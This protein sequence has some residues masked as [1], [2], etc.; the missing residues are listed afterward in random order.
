[1]KK[2][3]IVIVLAISTASVFLLFAGNNKRSRPADRARVERGRF[4]VAIGGCNDCHTP[5]KMGE[6]GPEPDLARYLSGHPADTKLPPP[7]ALAGSPWN[8]VTAGLTAWSGPWGVSYAA[9]LTP[10]DETGLGR[11][12]E[13]QFLQIVHTGR[14]LGK[15][16]GILPPMPIQN[17]QA[18]REE[19]L[20]AIFAYLRSQPAVR[21]HVPTATEPVASH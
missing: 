10:D 9:N 18:T 8:A 6:R 13:A 12:T 1:M 11:W 21:N 7:P 19:D 16:R 15:G 14:H 5:L 2:R 4:L 20:K 3:Q 17:L